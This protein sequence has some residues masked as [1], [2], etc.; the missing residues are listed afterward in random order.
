M[1][2]LFY[3][4]VANFSIVFFTFSQVLSVS[5]FKMGHFCDMFNWRM[6]E[7]YAYWPLWARQAGSMLQ[8][9][10]I[11]IIPAVGIIQCIRYLS[12]GPSD[13]FDVSLENDDQIPFYFYILFF[14]FFFVKF[15]SEDQITLSSKFSNVPHTEPV[16]FSDCVQ[17]VTQ[18]AKERTKKI[19]SLL[20]FS[21][22]FTIA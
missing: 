17:I 13:L 10:P 6:S 22:T 16:V 14:N 15:F 18:S 11:L 19:G 3:F 2:T 20:T 8:L 5:S 4:F 9:I 12:S 1:L 7:G 21:F